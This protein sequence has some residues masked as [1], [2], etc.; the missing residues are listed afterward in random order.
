MANPRSLQDPRNRPARLPRSGTLVRLP[1][2]FQP[3]QHDQ[4]QR[5]G[6]YYVLI[7]G[8][9]HRMVRAKTQVANIKRE[10]L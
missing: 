4:S 2:S 7:S 3:H 1:R 8:A 9:D 6:P 5:R 10:A